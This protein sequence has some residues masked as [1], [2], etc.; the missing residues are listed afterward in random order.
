MAAKYLSK[1]LDPSFSKSTDVS[2]VFGEEGQEV[3]EINAHKVILAVV[4]DVFNREFFGSFTSENRIVIKDAK[5]EVFQTM[6]DFI[7][8]KQLAWKDFDLSYLCSLYYL[9]D[10]YNIVE[11]MDTIIE[12]I[13][14]YEVTR[15]NVLDIALLGEDNILHDRLSGT[16]YD[17][18]VG[19]LEKDFNGKFERVITF[20]R[21]SGADKM[22]A[23][24]LHKIMGL[25][26]KSCENCEKSDCLHGKQVTYENFVAGANVDADNGIKKLV[27]IADDEEFFGATSSETEFSFRCTFGYTY[28]FDCKKID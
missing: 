21:E 4:S 1:C 20:F 16:L 10:K 14:E 28:V 23:W 17:L 6:I 11:L 2:F 5:K 15:M 19:F 27:R 8:N 25:M 7:Y 22:Q 12:T 24:V 18:A 13:T 9:G 3:V 26:R